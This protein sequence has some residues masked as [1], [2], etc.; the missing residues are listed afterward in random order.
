MPDFKREREQRERQRSAMAVFLEAIN[1]RTTL[2]VLLVGASFLFSSN[3]EPAS[4]GTAFAAATRRERGF[5]D[6][7][8]AIGALPDPP[9][10]WRLR[11][12][13]EKPYRG[14]F[15]PAV[16]VEEPYS[17]SISFGAIPKDLKGRLATAG[18]GRIRIGDRQYGHWFDG[19]GYV[20]LLGLDGSSNTSTFTGRYVRSKRFEA[21]EELM[22]RIRS[23]PNA[24]ELL[25]EPPLAFSGAWTL[26]GKGHWY[27]NV[28][29]F[30]TNPANTA[31]MW[32]PPQQL[33]SATRSPDDDGNARSAAA[34]EA[35]TSPRLFAL[36]EGGQPIELDPTTLETIDNREM[37][38][39]SAGD[40]E[41]VG[42]FFSAHFK[43]D[44]A[45]GEIFNHGYL[46]RPGPLPKEINV[47]K[48]G[49]DGN[50][51][52]Q[53]RSSL[54]F[55]ALVHDSALSDR[56]YV[57]LLPPYFIPN[58]SI[59]SLLTGSK[60][61]G[62]LLE[63]HPNSKC[64]VQVHSK[65]GLKLKW[66]IELPRRMSAYHL[67]DASDE[68]SK[69]GNSVLRVRVAEHFPFDRP[70]LER[71]FKDQY[72]VEDQRICAVLKEYTFYVNEDGTASS[73]VD[74]KDVAENAAP[75]EYPAVHGHYCWTNAA[76][77]SGP[78]TRIEWLDGIQ[79][80]DMR[81]GLASNVKTFGSGSYA[82]APY[83]VPKT[84]ETKSEDEGYLLV[85]VYQSS[86]H[87]S[88]VAILDAATLE[89]LCLMELRDHVPY[90]FHGDWCPG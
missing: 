4:R 44:R 90:Q 17:P 48:L 2:V 57:Y 62:T 42:S 23:R 40:G 68:T 73:D 16:D 34:K 53:A 65:D 45:S 54:P 52:H 49:P 25:K 30:P 9:S 37:P 6:D 22:Q 78:D 43:R 80:V 39:V 89:T 27:E 46:V 12:I 79:K 35:T 67:V 58:D 60:P 59:L 32:I 31:T 85:T 71:Q 83:F 7:L 51:L 3:A 82:G 26:A 41:Q 18:P 15:E 61:L 74:V 64:Y 56:Y 13:Q 8:A 5:W 29:R 33:P 21:Q 55:D 76:S 14:G 75:C 84:P 28:L 11:L 19:D 10:P 50:L 36:C 70:A 47:M 81:L 63:W 87:R 88:D 1:E 77:A 69:D 20:T 66:R 86:Q 38:F 72:R 24:E